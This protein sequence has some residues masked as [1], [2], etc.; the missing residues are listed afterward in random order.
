MAEWPCWPEGA[1]LSSAPRSQGIRR[2]P[3]LCPAMCHSPRL[4]SEGLSLCLLAPLATYWPFWE[5]PNKRARVPSF[6]SN[7]AVPTLHVVPSSSTNQ[8]LVA[9][10]T[11]YHT[12]ILLRN[13]QFTSWPP[14]FPWH[15]F[16]I[17]HSN[18]G[19]LCGTENNY[20]YLKKKIHPYC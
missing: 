20:W 10:E 2:H 9:M 16:W 15:P 14:S 11:V 6:A 8:Y 1:A 7:I 3:G 4:P 13:W 18:G 17:L 5:L 12:C 19:S